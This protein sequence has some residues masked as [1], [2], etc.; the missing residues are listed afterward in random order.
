MFLSFYNCFFS[1]LSFIPQ[2]LFLLPFLS[3]SAEAME[4]MKNFVKTS[5]SLI[6]KEIKIKMH[7]MSSASYCPLCPSTC[8]AGTKDAEENETRKS[9]SD[10]H[11][12]QLAMQSLLFSVSG[13]LNRRSL[14]G[15]SV[16]KHTSARTAVVSKP[17]MAV[18]DCM[19]IERERLKARP[20]SKGHLPCHSPPLGQHHN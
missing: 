1:H 12:P 5:D 14:L 16:S 10:P 3:Q 11:C 13:V 4:D 18:S 15:S 19:E 17:S 9:N 20:F 2:F 6:C 8:A 7:F